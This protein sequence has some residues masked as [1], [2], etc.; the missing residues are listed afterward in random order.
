MIQ[1]HKAQNSEM[2]FHERLKN[3]MSTYYE[4]TVNTKGEVLTEMKNNPY[5]QKNDVWNIDTIGLINNFKEMHSRYNRS[6]KNIDFRL[7]N[8]TFRIEIKYLFYKKLFNDEWSLNRIMTAIYQVNKIQG[9]LNECYPNVKSILELDMDKAAEKWVLWLE[10]K[11]VNLKIT[12]YVGHRD[13]FEKASAGIVTFLKMIYS[14]IKTVT[15]DRVEWEKESWDIRNLKKL[16]GISHNQSANSYFLHFDKIKNPKFRDA[17]KKYFRHRLLGKQNFS[18]TTAG[19]YM[20]YVTPFFNHIS[21]L[22]PEWKDLK[23]L[24]RQHILNYIQWLHRYANSSINHRNSNPD[25]YVRQSLAIVQ[26]VLTDFQNYQYDTAPE[27]DIRI[28]IFPEDK[29]LDKKK[30][31]DQVD[32]LP[33]FVLDQLFTEINHLH[34]E[35]Q[36]IVWIAFKTGL[37]I[38]DILTLRQDCLVKLKGKY[39]IVTDIK[40]TYVAG[41]SIPLDEEI[42]SIIAALIDLSI[43]NSNSDNNPDKFIF[44]RYSGVRKG[45]PFS[46]EWVRQKLNTLAHDREIKTEDGKIFH[47]KTHQFRHTYAVKMLNNGTDI[48]TVKEL[49]AHASP[50]MTMRY[51]KLLDGTKRKVFEEAIKNGVFSFGK[52]GEMKEIKPNEDIPED[53]LEMLWREHKLT[54]IDNPYGTCHAR[55]NGNCPYSE[56]PP[57]LTCN[58]GSPCKD[59]AIGLSDMDV[60]KYELLVKTSSKTIKV[61]EQRGRHDVAQKNK[62]NL[63][64]Y[65]D[66]LKTI[67]DGNIIFGRLDRIKRKEGS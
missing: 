2:G 37:R 53:V 1:S 21:E 29:P 61:L 32:Y 66:I 46:Q 19:N 67:Q 56:E 6:T 26:K 7:L 60:P 27:K 28:L 17:V 24:Q 64:R 8:P 43:N 3:E 49:L 22:E 10:S 59:L 33:D 54:A 47:F 55:I 62:K 9:F 18:G 14:A 39:Q 31:Y 52:N 42:A 45:K 13:T 11:G 50:E 25:G 63:D 44:S 5:F 38:S 30:A 20:T 58:G 23:K 12:K 36:P 65:Q 48:L 4:R 57:C 15:D 41:H 51:A 16:Y 34:K 35:V 40:K